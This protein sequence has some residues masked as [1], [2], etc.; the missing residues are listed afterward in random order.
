MASGFP[1]FEAFLVYANVRVTER[2]QLLSGLRALR[3]L[4]STTYVMISAFF[5]DGR[6]VPVEAVQRHSARTGNKVAGKERTG[7]HVPEFQLV[8]LL[9]PLL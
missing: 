8:T 6:R 9:E 2:H 3:A 7:L 4:R 5:R 1:S